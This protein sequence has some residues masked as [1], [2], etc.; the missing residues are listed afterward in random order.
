MAVNKIIYGGKTL[1]DLSGDTLDADK[2]LAGVTGHDKAGEA[3]TGT[4]P[5]QAAQTITPGK[6][7]QTIAA[8]KYLSGTQT[9]KGDANLVAENIAEGVSIFGVMGTHAGGGISEMKSASGTVSATNIITYDSWKYSYGIISGLDFTPIVIAASD[10]GIY[11]GNARDVWGYALFDRSVLQAMGQGTIG[12]S[13]YQG[14]W[15]AGEAMQS[16]LNSLSDGQ[17]PIYFICGYRSSSSP[18]TGTLN[19]KAWGV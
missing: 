13:S 16:L 2:M 6:A 18:T 15:Y 17:Y 19:W 8:G 7:D 9:I 11:S 14:M 4:I 5:S 1:I 12:G 3:I 10:N